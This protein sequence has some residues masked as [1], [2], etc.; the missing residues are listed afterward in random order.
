MTRDQSPKYINISCSSKSKKKKNNFKKMGRR[1]FQ[2]LEASTL[3]LPR[4]WVQSLA[5]E[6]I[7][8]ELQG[9]VKKKKME[10][11]LL[12][13]SLGVPIPWL[14]S[15]LPGGLCPEPAAGF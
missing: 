1:E 4:A 6:L 11:L 2:W 15:F 9:R 13:C 3:S 12:D 7:S 14:L 8:H 10:T 5:E